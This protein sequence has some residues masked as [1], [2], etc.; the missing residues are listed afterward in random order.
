MNAQEP[1]EDE[2]LV[3]YLL[4]PEERRGEIQKLRSFYLE[5]EGSLDAETDSQSPFDSF[6]A[7]R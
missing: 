5:I 1:I 6:F 7:Q 2:N 4:S 3:W